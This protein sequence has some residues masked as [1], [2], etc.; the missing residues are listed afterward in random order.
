MSHQFLMLEKFICV[1]FFF[2]GCR[3]NWHEFFLDTTDVNPLIKSAVSC[4]DFL[5]PSESLS[6]A[7]YSFFY[8][9][10]STLPSNVKTKRDSNNRFAFHFHYP[11]IFNN[12]EY[13]CCVQLNGTI[14]YKSMIIV[15]E[16]FHYDIR[17]NESLS[18]SKNRNVFLQL[19]NDSIF[20]TINCVFQNQSTPA[21]NVFTNIVNNTKLPY[22][23]VF[24]QVV[25]QSVT[26]DNFGT[27]NC[28]GIDM[29][30]RILFKSFNLDEAS[31]RDYPWKIDESTNNANRF[32][33]STFVLIFF[34]K[35]F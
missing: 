32:L 24:G 19:F 18:V 17:N 25:F 4:G 13:R 5:T 1:S 34:A 21:P 29:N 9:S 15:N 8:N 2:F 6:R 31:V 22:Y 11:T 35:F 28:T 26:A 10:N 7:K 23:R 3:Q 14:C 16:N 12:G 33:F 20:S 30:S 27:Y